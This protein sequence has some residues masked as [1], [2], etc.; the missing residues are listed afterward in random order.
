MI[1]RNKVLFLK[2]MIY[3][4]G[5]FIGN[6]LRLYFVERPF[7]YTLHY[8]LF[9]HNTNFDLRIFVLFFLEFDVMKIKFNQLYKQFSLMKI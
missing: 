2:N 1:I 5:L 6:A 7:T 4:F 8:N 9:L 3:C